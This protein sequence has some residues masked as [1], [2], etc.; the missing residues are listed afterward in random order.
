MQQLAGGALLLAAG[1]L[2]GELGAL[3]PETFSL[4][5]VLALGYL[6]VFGS[7]VAFTAYIWLLRNVAPAVVS[8]YA[9]VNPVIA[10]FLGWAL[11]A[12]PITPRTL[13]ASAMVVGAVALVTSEQARVAMRE[14]R[15]R[16]DAATAAK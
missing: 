9:Y 1:A 15:E 2:A 5:S 8:T 3:H 13:V 12:E 10:V 16:A 4:R 14:R 7:L 11:G 6:I